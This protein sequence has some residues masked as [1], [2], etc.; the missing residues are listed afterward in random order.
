VAARSQAAE[1]PPSKALLRRLPARHRANDRAEDAISRETCRDV[2]Q[3]LCCG[4]QARFG[5]GFGARLA[6][7]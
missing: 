5:D 4:H 6:S 2:A 3:A 1:T 7:A